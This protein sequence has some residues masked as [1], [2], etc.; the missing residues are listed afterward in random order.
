[1]GERG[2]NRSQ[3]CAHACPC[4]ACEGERD[5]GEQG[6]AGGVGESIEL[7]LSAQV[8]TLA[9]R[10]SMAY[11]GCYY[12]LRFNGPSMHIFFRELKC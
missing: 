6:P 4:V 7:G 8:S 10:T 5:A 2:P 1:M 3:L 9:P 11:P 12:L